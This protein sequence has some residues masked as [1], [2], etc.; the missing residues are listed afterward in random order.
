MFDQLEFTEEPMQVLDVSVY[1][2]EKIKTSEELQRTDDWH[3]QR[4]GRFTGSKIKELMSCSRSTA[5]FEWGR[6][7]KLID[8]GETAKKYVYSKAK[9]IQRNKIIKTPTS[10]AMQYG[11]NNEPIIKKLLKK[12]FPDYRFDEVGF[13]E[14]IEG[15]AGASPDGRIYR[16][17]DQIGLEIKAATDWGTIYSRHEIPIDQ[18]H[19]DFWQLQA[20]ML[21][22]RVNEIMY[23]VAEP[24]ESIF[25]P[26][27]T[28]LSIEYVQA[29]PI[30]QQAIINRC[31]IGRNAIKYYLSGMKFQLAINA[32]CREAEI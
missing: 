25:E 26:N 21:A 24:S 18:S 8:F 23:V 30:H 16:E 13:I 10:A 4:K 32:A 27:I 17:S 12:Q 7:E 6:P 28:D 1:G 22:L 9:E 14:F 31:M 2:I 5:K 3:Q 29:S 15:I 19:D 20:E 11:T